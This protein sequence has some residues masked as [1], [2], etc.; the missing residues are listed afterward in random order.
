VH[1]DRRLIDKLGSHRD[2]EL[3]GGDDC[4][5]LWRQLAMDARLSAR[6]AEHMLA[7]LKLTPAADARCAGFGFAHKIS[8]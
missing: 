7:E 1:L 3:V 4:S 5:A 6:S 2:A 8:S